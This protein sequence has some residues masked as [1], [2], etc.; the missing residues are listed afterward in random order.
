MIRN[1][2]QLIALLQHQAETNVHTDSEIVS[3]LAESGLD[4]LDPVELKVTSG[5][6]RQVRDP[7]FRARITYEGD[8]DPEYGKGLLF[9][10]VVEEIEGI[11]VYEGDG[12]WS[13]QIVDRQFTRGT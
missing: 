10:S 2:Q 4:S 12:F 11:L 1:K 6:W 9:T 13:P 8:W 7:K 5:S 3:L